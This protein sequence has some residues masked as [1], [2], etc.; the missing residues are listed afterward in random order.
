M[1]L[2]GLKEILKDDT[3]QIS[4]ISIGLKDFE[5]RILDL[6]VESFQGN[7][8]SFDN[9]NDIILKDLYD[10]LI[11]PGKDPIE[12][13]IEIIQSKHR[14]LEICFQQFGRVCEA[15]S[16]ALSLLHGKLLRLQNDIVMDIYETSKDVSSMKKIVH[17]ELELSISENQ[18]LKQDNHLLVEDISRLTDVRNIIFISLANL[19][20]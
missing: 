18:K 1:D 4:E 17:K 12:T 20:N 10:N 11:I 19:F 16:P 8:S 9:Q 15:L 14:L 13:H 2:L 6:G 5:N 7:G 3:T